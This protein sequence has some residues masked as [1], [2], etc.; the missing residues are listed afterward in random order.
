MNID[1]SPLSHSPAKTLERKATQRLWHPAR[2]KRPPSVRIHGSAHPPRPKRQSATTQRLRGLPRQIC[3][4]S[5]R[6]GLPPS[7]PPGHHSRSPCHRRCGCRPPRLEPSQTPRERP[8]NAWASEDTLALMRTRCNSCR[9]AHSLSHGI[10]IQNGPPRKGLPHTTLRSPPLR[11]LHALLT[12]TR[13]ADLAQA[14][15]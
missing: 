11:T 12:S 3:P 13:G 7:L 4:G 9:V 8:P 14:Q 5:A 10:D 1:R 6:Q 2:R 15:V